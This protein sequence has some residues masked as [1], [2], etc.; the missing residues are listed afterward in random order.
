MDLNSKN[1]KKNGRNGSRYLLLL[2]FLAMLTA[3][4]I[5]L[6]RVCSINIGNGY[7][8]GFGR[9]P[10]MLAGAWFGALPGLAVGA[11]ADVIGAITTT[12]W[13]PVLT[14]PAALAGML[15]PLLLRALRLCPGRQKRPAFGYAKMLLAVLVTKILTS[16]I[17]MTLLLAYFYA[18]Y[19]EALVFFFV[20]RTVI[21][22]LE[23]V[24][25]SVAIYI[26]YT[27][28]PICSMMAKRGILKG[29][30]Q[31]SVRRRGRPDAKGS[32]QK[33]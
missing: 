23:G 17:L 13:N 21:A 8:I 18:S 30:A 15:P 3:L 29:S 31:D 22:V 32:E 14:I 6:S 7:R 24:A 1:T 16:G 19:R 12:G 2:V 26:L 27:N 28:G 20:S 4:S 5:V 9:L 25:E 11:A 10:V 33:R